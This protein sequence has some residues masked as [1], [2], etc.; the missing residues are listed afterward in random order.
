MSQWRLNDGGYQT[1]GHIDAH[2]SGNPEL[3]NS[4]LLSGNS[5]AEKTLYLVYM[6]VFFLS[7]LGSWSD[8]HM[9]SPHFH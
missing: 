7:F 6:D 8:H 3:L 2:S 5:W 9:L 4:V 1:S